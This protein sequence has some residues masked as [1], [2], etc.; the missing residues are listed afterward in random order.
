MI[1]GADVVYS[2]ATFG[3]TVSVI[4]QPSARL[5][6]VDANAAAIVT[7]MSGDVTLRDLTI[8][9]AK[10][11]NGVDGVGVQALGGIL[12]MNRCRVTGNT[13]GIS[14]AGAAFEI[15]NTIVDSNLTG[16][17]VTLRAFAGAGPKT[18]AFNTVAGNTGAA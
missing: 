3:R 5:E 14:L 2:A 9:D 13:S 7:V 4:G 1:R 8:A 12:H 10:G 15:T 6:P 11:P 18:F 17:A 16:N